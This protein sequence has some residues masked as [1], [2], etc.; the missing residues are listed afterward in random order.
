[1]RGRLYYSEKEPIEGV[2]EAMQYYYDNF[3]IVPVLVQTHDYEGSVEFMGKKVR[4]VK[5]NIK[6]HIWVA[7]AD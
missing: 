7:Y 2:Q 6:Y 4:V 3:G 5:G 1:M